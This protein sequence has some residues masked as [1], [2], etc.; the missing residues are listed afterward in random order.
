MASCSN[1][2]LSR[3]Y[4]KLEPRDHVLLR[5]G[6]YIGSTES[7]SCDTWTFSDDQKS[8]TKRTVS[9]IPGLYKIFDEVL[10]NAIDHATRL[11]GDADSSLR[12]KDIRVTINRDNGE[13]EVFNSGQGIDVAV[14]PEHGVY[15]PELIFGNLLTSTNY[16]DTEERLVGGQNG[17]GAKCTNIFAARFKVETVDVTRKKHYSQEFFDNMCRKG[18]PVIRTAPKKPYTRITF[19]PD[20]ARFNTDGISDDMY[21]I[22]SKRVYDACALTPNEVTVYLNGQKL[23]YKTFERYADLYLGPKGQHARVYEK[24]NDR[25]EVIAALSPTDAFEHVS[26]VNGVWTIKGGRHIDC[27]S[28]HIAKRVCDTMQ[29]RK[30]LE[31]LKPAHVK[32][33]LMIFVKAYIPNATFDSQS[34]ETMTTPQSKFGCS[35]LEVSDAFVDK[36]CKSELGQALQDAASAAATKVLA[37]SD[38]KK[39]NILRGIAKLHDAG[40]AGSGARSKDA[41]LCLVEGDSA[42]AMAIAGRSAAPLGTQKYGIFALKGKPL[43]AR[44]ATTQKLADNAEICAIKKILGLE[45]GKTYTD[46]S[47]LRYGSVMLLCDADED[48]RHIQG[49]VCN[50]FASQWPSLFKLPG[51]ITVMR[52]PIVKCTKG[53]A[54]HSH[55]SLSEFNTWK[56]AQASLRGWNIKYYK[57]LA[58]SN[59]GEAKDYFRNIRRMTFEYTGPA[60]DT[61]LDLAF[62]KKRADDRKTWLEAFDPLNN[63]LDCAVSKAAFHEFVHNELIHFSTYDV[64]RSI[65]NIMDG[66]KISQRKILYACLKRNLVREI[67][68]AQLAG[69]VS[70]CSL[71]HHVSGQTLFRMAN[72]RVHCPQ[73]DTGSATRVCSAGLDA[74][75]F[76]ID[77]RRFQS[78][79]DFVRV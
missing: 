78:R 17:L 42:S 62:S 10:T 67:R 1:E 46:T 58:T 34:K 75:R 24:L 31:Q 79:G 36:L 76:R 23:E 41:V 20:F 70:E 19:V 38:G 72:R 73:R 47:Q 52:T 40:W 56:D 74:R 22:L 63:V 8:V 48:G 25:W 12:V 11:A 26:F 60:C 53:A 9:Y 3:K 54:T 32:E 43:N 28:Q 71:Y 6:M 5:S 66:L 16:D 61:A 35:R 37:K 68:V 14:H 4:Q 64:E 29:Q 30:K 45:T 27:L 21:A 69:W 57:G 51:F 39:R 55:Y 44:D 13:I 59:S 49:L 18:R 50:L 65:P 33:R 77:A 15:I 2:S 7:E